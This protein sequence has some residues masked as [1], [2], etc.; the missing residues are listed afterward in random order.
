MSF[1]CFFSYA[2]HDG[3]DRLNRFVSDLREKL[4]LHK[5]LPLEEAIFFD[6]AS[7]DAGAPWKTTLSTALR[8]SRVFLAICSPNYINSDYCGKEFQVFLER[9]RAYERHTDRRTPPNLIIPILWGAPQAS[10]RDVIKQFQYTKNGFPEVYSEEGLDYVM[11]LK[12]C[13]DDYQKFLTRLAATI[14]SAS[15]A[16]PIPIL[17]YLRSLEDIASAF[18][19]T[20]S[21]DSE[22]GDRAR[23]VFVAAKPDELSAMRKSLDRYGKAGGRDWRP[24]HPDVK[25]SVGLL[26]QQAASQYNRYFAEL[27]LDA[28]LLDALDEAERANEP[29]LVL[30]DPWA[31][32]VGRCKEEVRRLDRHIMDTCAIVVSWNAP[33]PDTG[34]E[35]RDALT[36]LLKETLKYRIVGGKPLHYWGEV[37]SVSELR[38]RLLDMLAHYTNRVVATTKARKAIA[39][40][41]VM[42]DVNQS[43]LP[44]GR[45]P[46]VDN[47]SRRI[48]D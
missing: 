30:V 24:Y 39:A 35:Q 6:G 44:L 48:N 20:A 18:H 13:D 31:L 45:L 25:D 23:F 46:V 5:T 40:E 19:A 3:G 29:V 22:E 26:A 17:P 12:G 34:D 33:D 43:E 10:L 16:H 36:E 42:Q 28:R 7:I 2:R 27:P 1:E 8:T 47:A 41:R 32:C 4:R 14:V 11:S 21:S 9:Y 37:N 15:K 38:R